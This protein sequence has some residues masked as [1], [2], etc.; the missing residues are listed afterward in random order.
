MQ[1]NP[2]SDPRVRELRAEITSTDHEIVS[3]V[4]HRLELVRRLKEHKAAMGYDFLDKGREEELLAELEREN[5]GP[6]SP[7]GLR[8][9]HAGLLD[10]TKREL[11]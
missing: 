10:L 8:E 9:L 4:N 1:G 7:E 2:G 5:G 3:A 6:L 11:D